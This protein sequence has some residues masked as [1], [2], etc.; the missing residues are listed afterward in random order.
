[1]EQRLYEVIEG[2]RIKLPC[3]SVGLNNAYLKGYQAFMHGR[4]RSTNPYR[5]RD[6]GSTNCSYIQYWDD[7]YDRAKQNVRKKCIPVDTKAVCSSCG[8]RTGKTTA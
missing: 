2:R 1:M 3:N 8:K 5:Q 7:G 6:G 4:H